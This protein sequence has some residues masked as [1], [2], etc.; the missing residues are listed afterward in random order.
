MARCSPP[1]CA[2]ARWELLP[3]GL[4]FCAVGIAASRFALLRGGN[5][6]LPVRVFARWESAPLRICTSGLEIF[7]LTKMEWWRIA[8]VYSVRGGKGIGGCGDHQTRSNGIL[9]DVIFACFKFLSSKNL[10]LVEAL[11]PDVEFAF[12]TERESALDVLHC[13]FQRGLGRRR[14]NGVKV[15]RH[16]DEAVEL[17]AAFG[18]VSGKDIE[19]EI[20]VLLD[21]EK[22]TAV[23][24]DGGDEV[25]AELLRRRE[26]HLGRIKE[27]PGLK[28]LLFGPEFRGLKA[29]APSGFALRTNVTCSHQ[30][31]RARMLRAAFVASRVVTSRVVEGWEL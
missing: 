26:R 1:V 5:C 4:R 25:G 2:F 11:R 14:K 18:P 10:S 17:I 9:F 24:G 13:L 21:L 3:P 27:S 23:G 29:L 16:D 15:V 22:T 6:C 8:K 30:E 12:E 31:S 19:E 20:S 7:R 28:P